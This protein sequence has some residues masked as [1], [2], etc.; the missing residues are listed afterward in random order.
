MYNTA[1]KVQIELSVDPTKLR[2]ACGLKAPSKPITSDKLEKILGISETVSTTNMH[3]FDASITMRRFATPEAM[4]EC[5][6]RYR[7][8]AYHRR[9][10]HQVSSSPLSCLLASLEIVIVLVL[11]VVEEM[12]EVMA[13][14][15]GDGVLAL[16]RFSFSE[17]FS[18]SDVGW[19][20]ARWRGQVAE[21]VEK[22][23]EL[24]NKARYCTMVHDGDL[25]VVKKT[26]A[27]RI[28]DLQAADFDRIQ[29]KSTRDP[30]TQPGQE[31]RD[32]DR[33]EGAEA[34]GGGAEELEGGGY[35]YLLRVSTLSCTTG[36]LCCLLSSH[37]VWC[38]WS[39]VLR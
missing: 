10:A 18:F 30:T 3:L 39:E 35:Q 7:L 21:M 14:G 2:A 22:V 6:F 33:E 15:G 11:V 24:S 13:V 31:Q 29:P 8:Q 9:K 25:S 32:E 12:V 37:G 4:L 26:V 20:V 5:F 28:A 17:F 16:F 38:C 27:L 23:K 36:Q 34:S 1:I 19:R